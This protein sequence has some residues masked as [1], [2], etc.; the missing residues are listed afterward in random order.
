MIEDQHWRKGFSSF[1]DQLGRLERC[2][3]DDDVQ[4]VIVIK[5]DARGTHRSVLSAEYCEYVLHTY[6]FDCR[7]EHLSEGTMWNDFTCGG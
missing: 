3:Q 4:N 5:F 2:Y 7:V 1:P 6:G